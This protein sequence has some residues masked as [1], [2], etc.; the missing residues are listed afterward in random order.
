[1]AEGLLRAAAMRSG[2]RAGVSFPVQVKKGEVSVFEGFRLQHND[3]V[4]R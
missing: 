1:M 2:V 4:R 3:L